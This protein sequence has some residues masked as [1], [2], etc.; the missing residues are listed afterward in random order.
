M[1]E[2]LRPAIFLD[3]DGTVIGE[4]HYLS[5]PAG[6]ELVPGVVPALAALRKAGYLLVLVTNQSGIAKGMYSVDDYGRVAARLVEVLDA[7][8]V[9]LDATYFCPHHPDEGP[10]CP[11]RKPATGMHRDAHRDLGVDLAASWY[12]GDKVSDVL[13]ALELGGQGILVRTGY[14]RESEAR[15][16]PAVAVVDDLAAAS[17]LILSGGRI[18]GVDPPGGPS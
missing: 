17:R 15:V 9:P 6:V 12:V 4:R 13:P 5:D 10:P 14:G 16:P 2:P 18:G 3:R 7:A 8:G 11:C 1:G